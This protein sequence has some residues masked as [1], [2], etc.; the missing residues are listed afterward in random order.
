[1]KYAK[2]ST[3][4]TAKFAIG[5]AVINDTV[6]R[7]AKGYATKPEA[8]FPQKSK[9]MDEPDQFRTNIGKQDFTKDGKGGALSELEGDT[10]SEKPIKPRA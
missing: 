3:P 5:G 7:F 10:K 9:F 2:G 6:S 8:T 1:M 4:T